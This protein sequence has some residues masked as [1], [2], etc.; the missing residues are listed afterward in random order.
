MQCEKIIRETQSAP[1]CCGQNLSWQHG[2]D[3]MRT[4]H[5]RN[6]TASEFIEPGRTCE[7]GV[8]SSQKTIRRCCQKLLPLYRLTEVI[9]ARAVERLIDE[10]RGG[11]EGALRKNN[12]LE[13]VNL[14][15]EGLNVPRTIPVPQQSASSMEQKTVRN[16]K[17]RANTVPES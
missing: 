2:T 9:Q 1:T 13:S 6:K 16:G 12:N 10:C 15:Y 11:Q 4:D 14:L 17:K 8:I 5:V 7:R 3:S